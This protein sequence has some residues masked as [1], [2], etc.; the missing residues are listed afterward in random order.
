[1]KI[2]ELKL[3]SIYFEDIAYHN[4]TF[5]YRTNDR[6]FKVGD[7]LHLREIN[8]KIEYTNREILCKVTYILKGVFKLNEMC[9]MSIQVLSIEWSIGD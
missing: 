2:H 3:S 8:N 6:D 4:K 9:I 7:I 5:E 1:M